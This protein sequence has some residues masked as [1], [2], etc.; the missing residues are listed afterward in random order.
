[1]A[2]KLETYLLL[3]IFT[4]ISFVVLL[5]NQSTQSIVAK[6]IKSKELEFENTI[7]SEVNI[8]KQLTK[9]TVKSAVQIDGVLKL[10]SVIYSGDKLK[11]LSANQA[12][13]DG[14]VS[15][16]SGNVVLEQEN[17][18]KYTS[19]KAIYNLN[20]QLVTIPDNFVSTIGQNIIKGKN[21]HYSIEQ[22]NAT[23]KDIHAILYTKN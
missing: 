8:E 7:F 6:Q 12:S 5:D 20:T 19:K 11:S 14:N 16:L 17:G 21:L 13:Y 3:A 4:T 23:A 1:M 22:G 9:A 15:T 2:I 10:N 18:A